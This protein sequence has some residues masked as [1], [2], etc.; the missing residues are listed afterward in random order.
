M[1]LIKTS[2]FFTCTHPFINT[3]RWLF[4]ECSYVLCTIC[5]DYILSMSWLDA[6]KFCLYEWNVG[7]REV[8]RPPGLSPQRSPTLASWH[9]NQEPDLWRG[10]GAPIQMDEVMFQH[11]SPHTEGLNWIYWAG[12]LIMINADMEAFQFIF[13]W[14]EWE[15][16]SEWVSSGVGPGPGEIHL[17][18]SL[19]CWKLL[20][21]NKSIE[22]IPTHFKDFK[23]VNKFLSARNLIKQLRYKQWQSWGC[24]DMS[25]NS[26]HWPTWFFI[27]I[28]PP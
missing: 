23:F 4:D 10:T 16:E 1:S 27:V 19:N 26:R 21:W 24:S 7:R 18:N 14:S 2:S 25:L 5:K 9:P 12:E 8:G 13:A 22:A 28:K 20:W 6:S 17:P 3:N 15:S 11:L